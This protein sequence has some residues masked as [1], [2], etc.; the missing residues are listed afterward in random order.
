MTRVKIKCKNSED[1]RKKIKLLEILC[2]KQIQVTKVF[3]THDGFATLLI[4]EEHADKI[5]SRE[6]KTDLDSHGFSPILPPELK[7]KKSVI[8]TRVDEIIYEKTTEEIEEELALQNTWVG[9]EIDSVYKFP[10]SQTIKVTFNQTTI[11]KKCTDN[12]LLA[13]SLSI[14]PSDIK[15]ETY[16]PITTCMK[17]YLIED[18]VTRDCPE[19]KDYKICSECSTLG[20]VW[21]QC[22]AKTKKCINCGEGHSSLAMRCAKRKEVIK[23]KRKQERERNNTT[24]SNI[25]KPTTTLGTYRP[26]ANT[27]EDMLRINT[28]ILHAHYRNL[29]NPGTYEVE[30]NKVLKLNNLPTIKIPEIPNS[31]KILNIPITKPTPAARK[32]KNTHLP[33]NRNDDKEEDVD[34]VETLEEMERELLPTCEDKDV[35]LQL[36]VSEDR[37]WPDKYFTV[38]DLIKGISNNI[39]KWTYTKHSITEQEMFTILSENKLKLKQCWNTVEKSMFK[40]IRSGLQQERSPADNRDPRHR[41]ISHN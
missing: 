39:Y 29:E 16:I 28:C 25:A 34:V 26:P 15:Q 38:P 3:N 31:S 1:K 14:P 22:K 6:L 37:G 7:C 40:K 8:I 20:H 13:F 23:L 12:G 5:F 9:D 27:N 35:G 18:H 33:E 2:S 36:Y 10:L 30:L 19:D 21:H 11:A 24:Y 4:N 17:C 41:K 32:E